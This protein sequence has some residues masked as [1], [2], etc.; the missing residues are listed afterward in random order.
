MHT[1]DYKQFFTSELQSLRDRGAY[2]KFREV[3]RHTDSFPE[4][5]VVHNG[6][7]KRV[8]VWCSNDY[9]GMG[10]CPLLISEAKKA[11]GDLGVGAGGTRNISGTHKDI[12]TLEKTFADVYG[13]ESALVFTSGYVANQTAIATLASRIPNLHIFSDSLNHDSIIQGIRLSRASKSIFRHNDLS[14]LRELLEK[15]PRETPKLIIFESVYSMEGDISDIE[16]TI[17]LAEEFGAL[18]FIDETHAVGLYGPKG[19]G[20][21]E[22]RGLLN[23]ISIIQGSMGKGYGVVGGFIAGDASLIDFVRSFGNGFIFTTSLPPSVARAATY[24]VNYL[25]S[26]SKEREIIWSN[27]VFFKE[28]LTKRA[29]PFLPGESHIVPLI[30]GNAKKCTQVTEELF[31]R[32]SI[33]AQPI[34]HPTVPEGTERLRLTATARHSEEQILKLV[35]ALDIL[36][37]EFSLPRLESKSEVISLSN[38][39]ERE[40]AEVLDRI[41]LANKKPSGFN[42]EQSEATI[43]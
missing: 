37:S 15:T 39:I 28:Q 22:Q 27:S 20:V 35:D 14:H 31:N 19:A 33:Y 18:T 36:W 30:I 4:I 43:N 7:N 8:T 41:K 34:N 11:E 16:G 21:A 29:L 3:V 2:R 10:H 6:E 9:L 23:R 38:S 17:E 42:I 26:S 32:F 24:S 12:V 25:A 40:R 1:F 13:K 5:D